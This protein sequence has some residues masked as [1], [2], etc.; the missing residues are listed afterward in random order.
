MEHDDSDLNGILEGWLPG[1]SADEQGASGTEH[2]IILAVHLTSEGL[3]RLRSPQ[4]YRCEPEAEAD[5]IGRFCARQR[6]PIPYHWPFVS[7]TVY[8]ALEDPRQ[9]AASV[10]SND[11]DPSSISSG[12]VAVLKNEIVIP[13]LQVVCTSDFR[14]TARNAAN[15]GK[16]A[17]GSYLRQFTIL[18]NLAT[19]KKIA[20]LYDARRRCDTGKYPEARLHRHLFKSDVCTILRN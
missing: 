15:K 7:L 6:P 5:S 12:Y 16:A 13:E 8:H 20:A 19:G 18:S 4:G 9:G 17:V 1:D 3:A 10:Y 11:P 14:T 2:D